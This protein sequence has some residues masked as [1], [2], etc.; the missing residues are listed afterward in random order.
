MDRR[1]KR[2]QRTV[3]AVL[4][5]LFTVAA[6]TLTGAPA[7]VAAP[8][9]FNQCPAI[10]FDSGC[11][12]LITVNADGTSSVQ[13]DANQPPFNGINDTLVG[14]VNNSGAPLSGLALSGELLGQGIFGFTQHGLCVAVSGTGAVPPPDGCPFGSTGYEGPGTSFS[15]TDATDGLVQFTGGLAS[16]GAAY[17]SIHGIVDQASVGNLNVAAVPVPSPVAVTAVATV[18][19]T[20]AVATFTDADTSV[21]P[22]A[23]TATVD[24]GDGSA[25]DPS[26]T[27]TESA[28]IFT[29]SGTHTYA[30]GG[31]FPVTVSI[32]DPHG[33]TATT[34][35]SAAVSDAPVVC[36]PGQQCS[37]STSQDGQ[38][39]TVQGTSPTGGTLDLSLGTTSIDCGDNKRH[40]PLMTTV[41]ETGTT[42]KGFTVVISFPKKD[43]IGPARAPFAVCFSSTVP[44]KDNPGQL[45]TTGD[46][47]SCHR[48][49][50]GANRPCLVFV[51]GLQGNFVE[52]LLIPA[53]DPRMW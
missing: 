18:P 27:V 52:K 10:G 2:L 6:V 49:P 46:L 53:Q 41:T 36:E 32:T 19:F 15:V 21:T 24:W 8:P 22:A 11:G 43:A 26:T 3:T 38:T 48:A 30:A 12:A 25:V 45:V 4:P 7:A 37:D 23:V 44:F 31:T 28:G 14:V 34:V 17:F 33:V 16:Q 42:G 35:G 51:V 47:R 13:F 5:L 40:A 20:G 9:A 29:V 50:P 1:G 39:T